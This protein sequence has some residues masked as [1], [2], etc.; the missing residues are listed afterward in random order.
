LKPAQYHL[1]GDLGCELQTNQLINR[2]PDYQIT[3]F[4]DNLIYMRKNLLLIAGIIFALILGINS[5]QRIGSLRDT[6]H[7]VDDAEERLENLRA[8]NERL[9]KELEYKKTDEFKE[10][11][12][13][14][15][16]G[17]VKEGEAIVIVPKMSDQESETS[18]QESVPNW[19]KWRILFFG[20]S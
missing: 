13:R 14:N 12:I 5:V 7:K 18:D 15:K 6:S 1:G 20:K 3:R 8:E 17:L 10:A 19:E 9:Q 2:I 16:L 11:E 4:P